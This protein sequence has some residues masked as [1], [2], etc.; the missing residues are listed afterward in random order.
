MR[1][2]QNPSFAA[3]VSDLRDAGVDVF[4]PI[5]VLQEAQSISGL[6]QF[7]ATDTHWTPQAMCLVAQRLAA[8]ID[9]TI[10]WSE[11]PRTYSRSAMSI[12]NTGD[13]AAMLRL[14]D[15][16]D[17]Y[18]PET[19]TI[20]PVFEARSGQQWRPVR[21][22]ELLLLGDSFSNIYSLPG[23]G[24]G[25]AAGFAEQLSFFLQ[26]PLDALLQND[27]GAWATR[28]LLEE[29]MRRGDDILDGKKI[30]IWEFAAR[31]LAFGDWRPVTLPAS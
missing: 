21:R 20:R 11:A 12:E 29:R 4:D 9:V 1:T 30:V 10:E 6:P 17:L 5:S 15:W 14:P 22:A 2:P 7:L 23:M 26:R 28:V 3:F 27:S 13:T 24:W 18:P 25:Q 8:S 19:V 31:E 16:A